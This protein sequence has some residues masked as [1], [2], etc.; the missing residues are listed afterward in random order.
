MFL[1]LTSGDERILI[2]HSRTKI[3]EEKEEKK[4]QDIKILQTELTLAKE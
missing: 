2:F 4:E 1:L 3:D